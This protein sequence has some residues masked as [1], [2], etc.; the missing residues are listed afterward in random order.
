[1]H[2]SRIY[3]NS[4]ADNPWMHRTGLSAFRVWGV[5]EAWKS[6]VGPQGSATSMPWCLQTPRNMEALSVQT[7]LIASG[8]PQSTVFD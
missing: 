6:L 4:D 1:M 5:M 7:W 8:A 2:P 3:A